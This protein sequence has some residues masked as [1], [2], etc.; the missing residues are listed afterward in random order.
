MHVSVAWLSVLWCSNSE[1]MSDGEI[2]DS[3][4]KV[5]QLFSFVTDK[6]MFGEMYR[7]DC[8]QLFP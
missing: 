2:E 4:E 8:E 3:L 6:D 7:Y 5:V 1:K